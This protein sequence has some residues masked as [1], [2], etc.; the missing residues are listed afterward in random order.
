[1]FVFS[2]EKGILTFQDVQV[3]KKASA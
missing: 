2:E 1:L 3:S